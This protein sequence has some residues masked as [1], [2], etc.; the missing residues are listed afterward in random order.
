[1][2]DPPPDLDA[3][4]LSTPPGWAVLYV[5]AVG[6]TVAPWPGAPRDEE[7]APVAF[8]AGGAEAGG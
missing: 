7:R 5:P 6:W 8:R 1:M 2:H 3:R 4:C